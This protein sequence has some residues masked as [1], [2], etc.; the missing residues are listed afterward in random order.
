MVV[1]TKIGGKSQ[2]THEMVEEFAEGLRNK[3]GKEERLIVVT[4]AIGRTTDELLDAIKER[5]GIS[6]ILDAHRERFYKSDG[7]EQA[8]RKIEDDFITLYNAYTLTPSPQLKAAL[9]MQPERLASFL[10]ANVSKKVKERKTLW[11]DFYDRRFPLIAAEGDTNYLSASV[12]PTSSKRLSVGTDVLLQKYDIFIPGFG[13]VSYK[14]GGTVTKTFG[15]G[16]SDEAAFGCGYIFGAD[17]IWICSDVEGIKRAIIDG[18]ETETIPYLDIEEAEAG[19]FLGA[20]LPNQ[21]ALMPLEESYKNG[22]KPKVYV[23]HAQNLNGKKTEI[24]PSLDNQPAK[25]VAG[26]D[27][28][29]YY[30]IEG[31]PYD[32]LN[33]ERELVEAG[34]DSHRVI[35]GGRADI[36]IFGKGS[37]LEDVDNIVKKYEK[38]LR[39][40]RDTDRAIVGVVGSGMETVPGINSRVAETLYKNGVNVFLSSDYGGS[41]VVSIISKGHRPKAMS[42]LYE[43][44]SSI[45]GS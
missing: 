6:L 14:N 32:L 39:V 44:L 30:T 4:S 17:E 35:V 45:R 29:I 15:R 13:G 33:L 43:A 21:Q 22:W 2:N 34:I 20:K 36:A 19:A 12:D 37:D 18:N 3:F 11:I 23:A 28:V 41:S 27:I 40:K 10:M 26:R 31:S 16:G 9:L 1:V 25:L 8:Y 7:N 38:G 42:S 24:G 5:S